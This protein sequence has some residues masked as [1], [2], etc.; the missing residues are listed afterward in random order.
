MGL[1]SSITAAMT[2]APPTTVSMAPR[3][4]ASRAVLR[5]PAEPWRDDSSG[6]SD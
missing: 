3:S 2:T 6:K 4:A 1:R 5:Y